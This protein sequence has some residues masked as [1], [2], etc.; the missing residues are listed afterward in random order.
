MNLD[1]VLECLERYSQRATYR[2]VA[3]LLG[4]PNNGYDQFRGRPYSHRNAW[5]VSEISQLPTGYDPSAFPPGF[6][7]NSGLIMSGNDLRDWLSTHH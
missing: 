5:V 7:T 6:F 2:A 4:F 3:E 1:D